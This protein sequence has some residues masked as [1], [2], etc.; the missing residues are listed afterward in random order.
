MLGAEHSRLAAHGKGVMCAVAT[1]PNTTVVSPGWR[2]NLNGMEK[3]VK[4]VVDGA[5]RCHRPTPERNDAAPIPAR[6]GEVV[7]ATDNNTEVQDEVIEGNNRADKNDIVQLWLLE[8]CE[9][10]EYGEKMYEM[11]TYVN[12]SWC[13]LPSGE[14]TKMSGW[15]RR[16]KDPYSVGYDLF[17]RQVA[18]M[19]T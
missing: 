8:M 16:D 18:D 4:E 2:Q 19:T 11:P 15:R 7:H 6:S 14:K 17:A 12:G 1:G 9:S 5:R 3:L 13:D 10:A